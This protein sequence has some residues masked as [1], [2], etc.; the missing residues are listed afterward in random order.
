MVPLV[1]YIVYCVCWAHSSNHCK[2]TMGDTLPTTW[3]RCQIADWQGGKFLKDCMISGHAFST[4]AGSRQDFTRSSTSL[5]M[6]Q[7]QNNNEEREVCLPLC[8]TP[9]PPLHQKLINKQQVTQQ[10]EGGSPAIFPCA[11]SHTNAP[12]QKVKVCRGVKWKLQNSFY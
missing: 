9:C 4:S 5:A 6:S 3:N 1:I 7:K 12:A 8:M 11:C 2:P 10:T